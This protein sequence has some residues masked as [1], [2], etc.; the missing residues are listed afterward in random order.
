MSLF[1]SIRHYS[2]LTTI[3]KTPRPSLEETVDSIVHCLLDCQRG[4]VSSS[5]T[6][7]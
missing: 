5:G 7:R 4:S 6:T 3:L 1:H 2:A